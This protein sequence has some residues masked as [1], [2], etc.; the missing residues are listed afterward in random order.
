[1]GLIPLLTVNEVVQRLLNERHEDRG[2]EG[3]KLPGLVPELGLVV[4][5]PTICC[6]GRVRWVP[7]AGAEDCAVREPAGSDYPWRAA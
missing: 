7:S 4:S 1:M 6:L 3:V 2:T 5:E